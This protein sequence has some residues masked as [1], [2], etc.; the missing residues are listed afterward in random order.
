MKASRILL[1]LLSIAAT[2]LV[3]APRQRPSDQELVAPAAEVFQPLEAPA[4]SVEPSPPVEMPRMVEAPPVAV[5]EPKTPVQPL[6]ERGDAMLF[7][8]EAL[9]DSPFDQAI[10][11]P[12]D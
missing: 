12:F 3:V 6:E 8:C 11:M 10:V 4:L 5:E 7:E 9:F 1:L 2:A